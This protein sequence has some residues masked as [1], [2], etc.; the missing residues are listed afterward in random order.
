MTVT[1]LQHLR[2]SYMAKNELIST[3]DASESSQRRQLPSAQLHRRRQRPLG[4]GLGETKPL[5]AGISEDLRNDAAYWS[6]NRVSA[7][8]SYKYRITACDSGNEPN[9]E[10]DGAGTVPTFASPK[11]SC[12]RH[13]RSS[14][15]NRTTLISMRLISDRKRPA[16]L[17]T[18]GRYR[19]SPFS[20]RRDG[21]L[22]LFAA[23][24][25]FEFARSAKANLPAI[26][27]PGANGEF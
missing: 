4:R 2:E 23:T 20:R 19:L 22:Q 7:P 10:S 11:V 1:I 21:V 17:N 24:P 6:G 5:K 18:A 13:I 27:G 16:P 3:P 15:Q 8:R 9:D 12:R 25:G 26:V 14:Q